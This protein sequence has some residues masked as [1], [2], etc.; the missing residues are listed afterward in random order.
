M[1]SKRLISLIRDLQL[2]V[3]TSSY[4]RCL[5]CIVTHLVQ[6]GLIMSQLRLADVIWPSLIYYEDRYKDHHM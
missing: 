3:Y 1:F 4:G 6:A 5:A 2:N